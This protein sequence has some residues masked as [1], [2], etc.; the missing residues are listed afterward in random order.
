MLEIYHQAARL[1]KLFK[2]VIIHNTTIHMLPVVGR[3]E[4]KVQE[5]KLES[6]SK[7]FPL[8]PP[9]TTWRYKLY[10]LCAIKG[11]YVQYV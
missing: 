11:F 2:L 5:T 4:L 6:L 1:V 9:T 7:I 8:K 10:L 3:F